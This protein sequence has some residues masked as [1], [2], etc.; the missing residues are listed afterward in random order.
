MVVSNRVNSRDD[1]QLNNITGAIYE[2]LTLV[3]LSPLGVS[4]GEL[5]KQLH[6]RGP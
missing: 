5:G 3:Q 6:E 2:T 4:Y 1:R